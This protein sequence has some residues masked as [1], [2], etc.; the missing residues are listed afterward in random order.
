MAD[1]KTFNETVQSLFGGM[2]TFMNTKTVVGEPVKVGDALLVPLIDV[3]FGI[4]A[5]AWDKEKDGKTS[6][7]GG[8]GGKMQ[9]T[10]VL[11]IRDGSVRVVDV[12]NNDPVS[13]IID[14]VPDIIAKFTGSDK[15][16]KD[17]DDA[18]DDIRT[19][20]TKTDGTET[21]DAE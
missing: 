3:S 17:I 13:R 12:Q 4:A 1:N 18:V 7:A 2:N 14:M 8:M 16:G 10:A 15:M 11:V 19:S 5:G 9:P 21:V 20:G 6:S